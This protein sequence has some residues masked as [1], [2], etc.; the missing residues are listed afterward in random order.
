MRAN[1]QP[2]DI[3]ETKLVN[4]V[5]LVFF[6]LWLYITDKQTHESTPFYGRRASDG[7]TD[8]YHMRT[9]LVGYEYANVGANYTTDY[10]ATIVGLGVWQLEDSRGQLLM[11][12]LSL[13]GSMSMLVCTCSALAPSRLVRSHTKRYTYRLPAFL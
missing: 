5:F 11:L 9:G 4:N 7:T 10:T 8:E 12:L 3:Y 6:A 2:D 1:I 13:S